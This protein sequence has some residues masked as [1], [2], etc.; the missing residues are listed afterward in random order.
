MSSRQT[1]VW[2]FGGGKGGVGRSFLAASLGIVLARMGKSVVAVDA[3]LAAPTL[4]TNLGIK[5]P[6]STLMD[7]LEGRIGLDAVLI[8]TIEPGLHLLSCAGDALGTGDLEPA[9]R[10]RMMEHIGGLDADIVLLDLGAG[11]SY[12]VLDFFNMSDEPF[13]VASTEPA[14]MQTAFTFVRNAVFRRVQKSFGGDES[15]RAALE[16][17]GRQAK[18]ARPHTM[19]DFYDALSATDPETAERTADLVDAF[20]PLL[21]VNMAA[22]EQDCRAAEILQSACRKFLNIEVRLCGSIP[23]DASVRQAS[24]K[25]SPLEIENTQCAAARQVHC[26]AERILDGRSPAE[27]PPEPPRTGEKPITGLNHNLQFQGTD[28]HIQTEDLGLAERSITTQVF[29]EGRVILSTKSEYPAALDA[30]PDREQI[31]E[32]MRAQHFNVMREIESRDADFRSA[33]SHS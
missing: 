20:R 8:E 7:A 18:G 21:V 24:L 27:R 12:A 16:Q 25:M 1:R 2:A 26:L 5:S 11:A 10:E 14:A 3:N 33:P 13:V 29:C 15:V 23:Y 19:I 22:S 31:L 32:L 4:H 9:V 6:G 30:R 28:L 17:V